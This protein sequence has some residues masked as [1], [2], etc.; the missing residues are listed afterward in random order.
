[1]IIS[2]GEGHNF[3]RIQGDHHTTWLKNLNL[4]NFTDVGHIFVGKF[5]T[6]YQKD[7]KCD[8]F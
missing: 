3:Y 8:Y 5:G 1:M 6:C 2:T 4:C 7:E